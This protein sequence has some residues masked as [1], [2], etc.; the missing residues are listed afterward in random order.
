MLGL[1]MEDRRVKRLIGRTAR[2][3]ARLLPRRNSTDFAFFMDQI[4][5]LRQRGLKIAAFLAV[6]SGRPF[7]I[8]RPHRAGW[9]EVRGNTWPAAETQRHE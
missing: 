8:C 5:G 6:S 9:I 7:P 4:G 3:D 1:D 2:A